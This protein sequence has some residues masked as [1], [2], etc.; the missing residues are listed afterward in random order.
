MKQK[1][2]CKPDFVR[3]L[4]AAATIRLAHDL[5]RES[6]NLPDPLGCRDSTRSRSF[7]DPIWFCTGWGLPAG[8]VTMPTVRSYR[9]ISPLP[10][11]RPKAPG[12]RYLSVALSVSFDRA[13]ALPGIL[14]CGVRTFLRAAGSVTFLRSGRAVI[15]LFHC[16]YTTS[17]DDQLR[18]F[19][20]GKNG[21]DIP[22]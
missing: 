1:A 13:R 7:L 17:G 5:H 4:H 15:L 19:V 9:T 6:S 20:A 14:P 22:H 16:I 10:R 2:T 8:H 18:K 12:R 3:R 21:Y 11:T